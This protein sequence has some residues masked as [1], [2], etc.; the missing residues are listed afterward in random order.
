VLRIWIILIQIRIL[1]LN[2]SGPRSELDTDPTKIFLAEIQGQE[3]L[4]YQL[5]LHKSF[6]SPNLAVKVTV[7]DRYRYRITG[8]GIYFR[9]IVISFKFFSFGFLYQV[10]SGSGI[11][12]KTLIRIQQMIWIHPDPY[13]QHCLAFVHN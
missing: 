3:N 1:F 5:W 6:D 4:L 11:R 2:S 13:P 8:T 12:I 7:L 10:G 9:K